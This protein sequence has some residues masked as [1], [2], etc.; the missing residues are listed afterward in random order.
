M[1][2]YSELLLVTRG[3]VVL[4][5]VLESGGIDALIPDEHFVGA[6]SQYGLAVGGVRVMVRSSD[7][8]KRARF[9]NPIR[10]T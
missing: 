9:S 3:A 10:K 1:D 5:S 8:S 2:R 4:R 7:S 6:N